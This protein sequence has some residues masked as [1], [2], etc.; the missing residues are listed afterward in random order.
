MRYT[1]NPL[2]DADYWSLRLNKGIKTLIAIF[3][4]GSSF[5]GRWSGVL[6][7]GSPAITSELEADTANEEIIAPNDQAALFLEAE[8]IPTVTVNQVKSRKIIVTGYS[9]TPDQTDDTPFV[10]ASGKWVSEGIAAD[11]FLP[12]GTKIRL[13]ELFGN[14]VF[15]IEDRMHQKYTDDRI[16]IWFPD[17]KTAENFGIQETTLEILQ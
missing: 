2:Q 1:N 15:I 17:R 7:E 10:T 14:Q 5:L 11:N 4:V 16:D 12:F 6:V 9:S 13:P 3:I 8:Y